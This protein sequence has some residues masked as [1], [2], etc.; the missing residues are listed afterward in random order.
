MIVVA[1]CHLALWQIS[2]HFDDV[3]RRRGILEDV[4][5][6]LQIAIHCL[7]VKEKDRDGNACRNNGVHDVVPEPNRIESY[8]SH[9]RND[10]VPQ[11]VVRRGHGVHGNTQP[12]GGY[13]G[14]VEEVAAKESEWVEAVEQEDEKCRGD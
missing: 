11:P 8:G 12:H 13:L 6:Q 1:I 9:H 14:T 3:P 5:Q 4:V 2:S 10:K 7:R